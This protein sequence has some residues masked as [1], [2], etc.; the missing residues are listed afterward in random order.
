MGGGC[1]EGPRKP[2]G[3]E[4]K[5][6]A[7]FLARAGVGGV[8]ERKGPLEWGL[9][10]RRRWVWREGERGREWVKRKVEG[11][12]VGGEDHCGLGFLF[13]GW[14]VLV[15]VDSYKAGM[16]DAIVGAVSRRGGLECYGRCDFCSGG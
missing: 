13:P 10:R 3:Y 11:E 12:S 8:V 15:C 9:D 16:L 14:G 6:E 1:A 7:A 4:V 2:R 5:A